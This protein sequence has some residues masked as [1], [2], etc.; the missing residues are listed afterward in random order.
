MVCYPSVQSPSVQLS[1]VQAP[2]VQASSRQAFRRIEPKRPGSKRP[3]AQSP[4]VQASR[5]Q[6]SRHRE[7]SFSGMQFVMVISVVLGSKF[8]SLRKRPIV[9]LTLG[10]TLLKWFSNI[11]FRKIIRMWGWLLDSRYFLDK[12]WEILLYMMDACITYFVLFVEKRGCVGV[13]DLLL[14]IIYWVCLLGYGLKNSIINFFQV[15]I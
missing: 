5:V 8:Q 6:V 4:S 13:F 12:I 3:V 9:L 15:I 11:F 14:K 7:S 1:R 2:R 10:N